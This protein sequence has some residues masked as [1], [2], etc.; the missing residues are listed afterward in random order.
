MDAKSLRMKNSETLL[1]EIGEAQARLKEL[2]F[3]VST[4]QLKD[5]REIREIKHGIARM[6]TILAGSVCRNGSTE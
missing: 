3:R 4:N 6:K 1:K 2:S 5:V